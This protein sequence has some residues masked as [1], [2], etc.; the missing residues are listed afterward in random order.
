MIAGQG[1]DMFR[2]RRAATNHDSIEKLRPQFGK[3]NGVQVSTN[4]L[5]T[6]IRTKRS[7]EIRWVDAPLRLIDDLAF[8]GLGAD[9][10]DLL[11]HGYS[12]RADHNEFSSGVHPV[13]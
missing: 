13:S 6:R 5:A 3:G 9:D 8:P 10:I 2:Q 11:G 7:D 12:S 1:R 4:L